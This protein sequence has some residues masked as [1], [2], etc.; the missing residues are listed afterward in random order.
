MTPPP[1]TTS[2]CS[3]TRGPVAAKTE[4]AASHARLNPPKL[5]IFLR[6]YELRPDR[7]AAA[8]DERS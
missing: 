7:G 8:S 1:R 3:T 4:L 5:R 6:P 2:A